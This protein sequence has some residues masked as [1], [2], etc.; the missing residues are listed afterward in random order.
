MSKPVKPAALLLVY[1]EGGHAEEMQRLLTYIFPLDKPKFELVSI[2]EEEAKDLN[3]DVKRYNCM[4]VRDKRTGIKWLSFFQSMTSIIKQA[5]TV[6]RRYDVRLMIT[7][8]PGLAVPVSLFAKL[9]NVNILHVETCC[10]FYSKSLTGRFMEILADEFWV[11]N[12]ELKALYPK[13]RWCG[14]L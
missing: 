1:G 7:L 14:R 2:V 4:H 9:F 6:C 8:G 5:L 3:E 12:E 11:Q 13:A 10:R